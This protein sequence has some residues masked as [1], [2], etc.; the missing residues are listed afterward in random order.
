MSLKFLVAMVVSILAIY[1]GIRV[2][3]VLF[4]NFEFQD[5]VRQAA[6][7]GAYHRDSEEQIA[8]NLQ[9]RAQMLGLPVGPDQIQVYRS[10]QGLVVDV[11]FNVRIPLLLQHAVNLHFRDQSVQQAAS[12]Y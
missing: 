8:A 9:Q 10:D 6:L 12:W 5:A 2:V 11:D 3:P 4:T 1:A 7:F